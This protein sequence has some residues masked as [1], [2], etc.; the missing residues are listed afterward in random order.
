MQQV[1]SQTFTVFSQPNLITS[2]IAKVLSTEAAAVGQA[3]PAFPDKDLFR[4]WCKNPATDH[5]FISMVEGINPHLRVSTRNMPA[6]IHGLIADYDARDLEEGDIQAALAELPADYKPTAWNRSFSGGL[7]VIWKFETPVLWYN[8]RVWKKF[9]EGMA[10]EMRLRHLL[11]L[12][13]EPAWLSYSKYYEAGRDWVTGDNRI[14]HDILITHLYEA[15]NQAGAL[16]DA[17]NPEIPFD[18]IN[19]E[20]HRQYPG[21][22][23]RE[24]GEGVRTVRF[25]DADADASA[26]IVSKRGVACFTGDQ[27]FMSWSDILGPGFVRSFQTDR[28]SA[29]ISGTYFVSSL[30]YKRTPDERWLALAKSDLQEHLHV[31][32]GLN[33]QR[34]QGDPSEVDEA[35]TTLR[36]TN[37]LDAAFPFLYR[38]E[39]VVSEGSCRYLNVSNVQVLTP[40]GENVEWGKSFP[41]ISELL[42]SQFGEQLPHILAWM[43]E[44]YQSAWEGK[45]RKGH[46]LFIAGPAESGKTFFTRYIL[47]K[48]MGG[49]GEATEY[50]TTADKFNGNLFHQPVWAVD[51]A[52]STTDQRQHQAY[53]QMIKKAVANHS[54]VYRRMHQ[55]GVTLPCFS[56]ITVTMNDDEESIRMLPHTEYSILDKISF[57]KIVRPSI[58]RDEDWEKRA[59]PELADFAQFLLG[60]RIPEELKGSARFSIKPYHHPELLE[61]AQDMGP[62]SAT[63]DLVNAW[64]ESHFPKDAEGEERNTWRGTPTKLVKSM[65]DYDFD[66]SGRS[67]DSLGRGLMRLMRQGCPWV[68]KVRREYIITSQ[69]LE[70]EPF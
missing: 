1:Q 35:I 68:K 69:R 30:Y 4:D 28:I 22:V 29:A 20:V 63:E 43:A 3:R 24:L 39:E 46:A 17:S 8:S 50:L 53:T 60:H 7:H 67:A 41:W 12:F 42:D 64:R 36:L 37:H 45:L 55:S 18:Q 21:R 44:F 14:S 47:G 66:V 32:A 62:A 58:N 19:A 23:D 27:P 56:R 34:V 59:A 38:R 54:M 11:P 33:R 6:R 9:T 16:V 2:R 26:A 61:L 65:R 5:S 51:D 10:D 15:V 13:D 31:E 25:W 52:V 49:V 70:E 57:F 40:S 48:L